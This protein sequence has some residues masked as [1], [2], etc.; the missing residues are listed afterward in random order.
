MI[1]NLSLI[2]NQSQNQN[3]SLNQQRRVTLQQLGTTTSTMIPP[4]P[5]TIIKSMMMLRR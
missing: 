2:E 5:R 4:M 3:Q 1:L